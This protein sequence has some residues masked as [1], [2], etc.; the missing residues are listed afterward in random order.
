MTELR[1]RRVEPSPAMRDLIPAAFF[2]AEPVDGRFL[3]AAGDTAQE[4]RANWFMRHGH[5]EVR[6]AA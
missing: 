4:A 5:R 3:K 2:I 1:I 6:H